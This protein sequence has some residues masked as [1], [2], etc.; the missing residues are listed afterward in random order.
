MEF[1]AEGSDAASG[2]YM[3]YETTT[4][5]MMGQ[6]GTSKRCWYDDFF[7]KTDILRVVHL[8]GSSRE[9]GEEHE[10]NTR[11]QSLHWI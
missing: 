1:L 7:R 4:H 9:N 10:I 6:I 3:P 2:E 11:V 5:S 8:I